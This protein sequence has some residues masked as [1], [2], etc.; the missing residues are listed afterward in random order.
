MLQD[1]YLRR[2]IERS[3]RRGRERDTLA[4]HGDRADRARAL[5]VGATGKDS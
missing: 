4:G 2:H 1:R 5:A 3:R